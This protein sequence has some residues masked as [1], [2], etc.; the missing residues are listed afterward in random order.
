MCRGA[1]T[2]LD[3]LTWIIAGSPRC[4]G[5]AR[6]AGH[7]I[8]NPFRATVVG[9]AWPQQDLLRRTMLHG[10]A[11]DGNRRRGCGREGAQGRSRRSRGCEE[12]GRE[13][14]RGE[15]VQCRQDGALPSCNAAATSMGQPVAGKLYID[16][17]YKFHILL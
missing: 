4:W 15:G 5:L 6:T 7:A 1:A 12:R 13:S 8:S 17:G 9:Q 14:R 11:R 3:E 10:R 2:V 16:W